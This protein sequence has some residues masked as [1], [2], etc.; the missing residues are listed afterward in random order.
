MS[1]IKNKQEYLMNDN[2]IVRVWAISGSFIYVLIED[3]TCKIGN[4]R[5]YIPDMWNL[6]DFITMVKGGMYQL[7]KD[8]K[9]RKGAVEF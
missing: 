7:I 9:T 4:F 6:D 1:S 2:R 5:S 3:D 8:S